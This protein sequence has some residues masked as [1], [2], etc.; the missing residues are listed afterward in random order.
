MRCVSTLKSIPA[1]V[2]GDYPGSSISGNG[3][4]SLGARWAG[5][6]YFPSELYLGQGAKL[7]IKGQFSLHTGFHLAVSYNATLTLGSGY[8]NNN[9]TIDCFESITIGNNVAISKGVTLR[10]SDNHAIN[11]SEKISAPIH[12]GDHVWIGLNAIILKGVTIGNGA[13]VAVVT[14]DVP[15]NCLVGG[16]PAKVLKKDISWS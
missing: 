4:L 6:R 1:C 3:V 11:G 12:I 15:E 5:L 2:R 13:V 9:A 14:Q 8:I 16:V 10:D 7:V